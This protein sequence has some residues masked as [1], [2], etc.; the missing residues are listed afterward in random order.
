MWNPQ[1][2]YAY[3][4][5]HKTALKCYLN[6]IPIF[7]NGI[8]GVD[9]E[10]GVYGSASNTPAVNIEAFNITD[11]NI[12]STLSIN[13]HQATIVSEDLINFTNY[14]T[15][16]ITTREYGELTL[17]VSS[18]SGTGYLWLSFYRTSNAYTGFWFGVSS[19]KTAFGQ[20]IINN[21]KTTTSEGPSILTI[22]ITEIT[23]G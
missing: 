4:N 15:V 13:G 5:G 10:N 1:D 8:F 6:S 2:D 21:L 22:H 16:T 7:A 14:S 11:N 19:T 12:V 18:Y 3:V 9:V 23:I 17:N 20:S